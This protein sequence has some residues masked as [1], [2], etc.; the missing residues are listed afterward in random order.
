MAGRIGLRKASAE[1]GDELKARGIYNETI[2]NLVDQLDILGPRAKSKD[3]RFVFQTK[4]GDQRTAD[5]IIRRLQPQ[6]LSVQQG[7]DGQIM[8]DVGDFVNNARPAAKRRGDIEVD[9]KNMPRPNK[10][11]S[12][13]TPQTMDG[14]DPNNLMHK[15]RF[16]PEVLE[17]L[18]FKN[19]NVK[20][21]L[22]IGRAEASGDNQRIHEANTMYDFSY[23]DAEKVGDTL[24][25][26]GTTLNNFLQLKGV[27]GERLDNLL[28]PATGIKYVDM[29]SADQAAYRRKRG[30]EGTRRWMNMGG[31]S[32]G[33]AGTEIVVPGF[34]AQMEHQKPFT[35]SIDVLGPDNSTY[36]SDD[37]YNQAGY[38]ER[39][40]NAE[41]ND[42]DTVDYHRMRRANMLSLQ[43]GSGPIRLTK[44]TGTS[45]VNNAISAKWPGIEYSNE[46]LKKDRTGTVNVENILKGLEFMDQVQSMYN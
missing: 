3:S 46:R 24:M 39:Y 38:L 36:F 37:K 12:A 15:S 35:G 31:R 26:G 19:P 28:D 18:D 16:T 33:D 7:E 29:N 17:G 41:K 14:L 1:L 43:Q 9:I 11:T 30:V 25:I 27:S 10:K 45:G 44:E 21:G 32:V 42:L 6:E 8:I 34:H 13:W 2:R 20:R 4:D 23:E 40:E 22:A 5:E